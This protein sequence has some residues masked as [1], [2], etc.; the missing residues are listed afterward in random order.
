VGWG[1][2][3]WLISVSPSKLRVR[4]VFVG[5]G[6]HTCEVLDWEPAIR[7]MSGTNRAK[8]WFD[9]KSTSPA[10]VDVSESSEPVGDPEDDTDM[11][12]YEAQYKA[13]PYK[14]VE[15]PFDCFKRPDVLEQLRAH[16][17]TRPYSLDSGFLATIEK[18]KNAKGQQEQAR[19]AMND[20]RMTQAM[21][22]LQGWGL[23]V[24]EAEVKHA[25]RVGDAPKRDAVQLPHY[26]YAHQ[27]KKPMEA[28]AAGTQCFKDGEYQKAIAC[29]KR[30]MFI[31]AE[32]YKTATSDP[33]AYEEMCLRGVLREGP[34]EARL[35][36]DLH[37][38]CAQALLKME[39]PTEALAE[40]EAA[41]KKAPDGWDA[42]NKAHY[43]T[44]Q[45]HEQ[46][47]KSLSQTINAE[48]AAAAW[49]KALEAARAALTA[50]KASEE[51]AKKKSKAD[52]SP[53]SN[54]T[55]LQ[56]ELKRYQQADKD[57]REAVEKVNAQKL[58]D[59][60]SEA[61]RKKGLEVKDAP[62]AV[63]TEDKSKALVHKPTAGYVRDI[64]L[65][66][67]T[68]GW[69]EQN[70]KKVEHKWADGWVK[71]LSLN[72][73]QSDINMSIKEKYSK[74][75]MYYDLSLVFEWEAKSRL[76]RG[77]SNYGEMRG[78]MRMYNI[79]QDTKFELGGDRETSY[80]YE[81]GFHPQYHGACDPWATQLKEEVPELFELTAKVITKKLLPAV[82]EKAEK[83][84]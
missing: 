79:G 19:L 6:V 42:L 33:M 59:T 40:L 50:A 48:K 62:K 56:K 24:T 15:T 76:G 29:W 34:P 22:V 63:S 54:M 84:K 21:A 18:L 43:R 53:S 10:P 57:A 30:T 31:Y 46:I 26:E 77:P 13:D 27:F 73:D 20:P 55:H 82:E 25:E 5:R 81:L 11:A 61:R 9:G 28:K 23:S 44:A 71:I 39:R 7:S 1:D 72:T 2:G 65:S 14:D 4:R 68:T 67:F 60:E 37:S 58:R 3:L 80:M 8:D 64:D 49:E 70:L 74:R 12:A 41:I 45:A 75:A 52:A 32:A 47:A 38:N 83:V 17:Q 66:I 51:E 35:A 78:I 16:P 69:L 36:S